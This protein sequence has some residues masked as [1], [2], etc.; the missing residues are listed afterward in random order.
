MSSRSH[1]VLIFLTGQEE[2]EHT[3]NRIRTIAKSPEFQSA[4]TPPLQVYTLYS[5]QTQ[6]RQVDAFRPSAAGS[7]KVVLCTNVAET[8]LTIAGIRYVIDSGRVKRSSYSPLTGMDTLRVE[9]IAQD[10]AWQ[11]TGR[12]GRDSAGHCYRTY[13]M[14][15]YGAAAASTP[16]EI[17][18]ASIVTT[19]LQLAAIGIDCETFDFLDRPDAAAVADAKRQLHALGA[20]LAPA[21]DVRLTELGRQMARFPLDPRFSRMLLAAP[22]HGCLDAM[23][24]IVA[25]LAGESVFVEPVAETETRA[26]AHTAHAKFAAKWGDH[27]TLLAVYRAFE[28]NAGAKMWCSQNWLSWRN[29]NYAREVRGQLL[30]ICE[31][32]GVR[33]PER[34]AAEEREKQ[35]A[36]RQELND[37][38]TMCDDERSAATDAQEEEDEEDEEAVRRCLLAG[39]FGSVAQLTGDGHTYRTRSRQK[40]KIHPSSRL[41]R[42]ASAKP[43]CVLYTELIVT[44]QCYMRHVTAIEADWLPETLR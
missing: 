5:Q 13:T 16:P 20:L 17:L 19:V 26:H 9:R 40:V 39:L 30:A 38:E 33:A 7:R 32:L 10:Q 37:D 1:D 21:G 42:G 28:R 22:E 24:S 36:A 18:R 15:E 2:I 6:Q 35:R 4:G 8:S 41:G 31:Q 34:A 23:L 44:G 43:A 12:A 3:A 29:L 25:V 27:Q 11:R 14:A